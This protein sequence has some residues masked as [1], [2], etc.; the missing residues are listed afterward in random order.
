MRARLHCLG[1]IGNKAFFV[2][3][4]VTYYGLSL[5]QAKRAGE[6]HAFALVTNLC[7]K[8]DLPTAERNNKRVI[9]VMWVSS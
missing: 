7:K 9:S 2:Q 3:R 8:V 1:E 6:F 5:T 4:G